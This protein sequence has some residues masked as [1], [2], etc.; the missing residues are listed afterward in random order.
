MGLL[1]IELT[2][3]ARANELYGV[4]YGRWLVETLSEGIPY[5]GSGSS[6]VAASPRV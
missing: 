1:G 4:S 3:M 6:L 5:K 2:P